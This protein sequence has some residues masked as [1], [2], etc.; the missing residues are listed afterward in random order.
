MQTKSTNKPFLLFFTVISLIFAGW[1]IQT[2]RNVETI[3]TD[4]ATVLSAE[5]SVVSSVIIGDTKLTVPNWQLFHD[6]EVWSLISADAPLPETYTP[7]LEDAPVNH[8][9]GDLKVASKISGALRNMFASAN[10]NGIELMLSSAYRSKDN[11][12]DIY[13]SYL[14]TQGQAYV[15]AYVALPGTS[16]HQTGLAVDISSKSTECTRAASGCSLD[17]DAIVWLNNNAMNFGFIQRYPAGKQSITGI[18]GEAWH[19]RYVGMT[20]ARAL[21]TANLTLDEFVQQTAPGYA[22]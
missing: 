14:R 4:T 16:E 10:N 18:A 3:Y 21:E 13:N 17:Y 2:G 5:S 12:Q 1:V 22:K 19:Y 11:Q 7:G 15:D 8:T 6:G 9:A 20:L